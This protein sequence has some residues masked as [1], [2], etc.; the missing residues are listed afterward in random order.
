MSNSKDTP[1]AHRP[2]RAAFFKLTKFLFGFATTI[3]IIGLAVFIYYANTAKPPAKLP[4]VDGIVVLTGAD[5]TRLLVGADLLRSG[6]GERLLI[7]GVNPDITPAQ[8]QTLLQLEDSEFQCCVDLDYAAQNTIGN[9][10]ET[11]NWVRVLGYEKIL[12]VTSAYHMPRAEMEISTLLED[13]EIIP[14][15][16]HLDKEKSLPWWGGKARTRLLLREYGKLLVS[17]AREPG[18]RSHKSK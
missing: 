8:V 2:I 7:S 16:V 18:K 9:A 10:E 5:G 17:Y 13:V 1:P 14:Y 4:K 15:P 11:A 6:N 12:L 3:L